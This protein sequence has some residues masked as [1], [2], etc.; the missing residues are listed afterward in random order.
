MRKISVLLITALL[1]LLSACQSSIDAGTEPALTTELMEFSA[2]TQPLQQ[3]ES[4]E[5]AEQAAPTQA[6][7]PT[8]EAHT[9]EYSQTTVKPTCTEDGY[10][11][12]T[13]ECGDSYKEDYVN[14]NGHTWGNWK[15][16]TEA[17]ETK[18]GMEK[19]TCSV[20]SQS[21]SRATAKIIPNHTHEYVET[22]ATKA[23]C[24]N[25]GV[26]TFACSCGHTYTES[27]A[28]TSHQY[29]HTIIAPTCTD[30][31]YTLYT[32]SCGD[33]YK[34]Q[35]TSA[36]GHSWGSWK[37]TK[38]PTTTSA[39]TKE[40]TCEKCG[41]KET[42]SIEK[43]TATEPETTAPATTE[44]PHTHS[45][46]VTEQK[47]ADCENYGYITQTCS[48]GKVET[49]L[50]TPTGHSWGEWKVTKEPTTTSAGTKERTC[51]KCGIKETASIEK[52][53][54]TEPETTAP[55]TTEPPHTHSYTV[56]D[57]KD[58]DCENDGY[59]TKNCSCGDVQT[60]TIA[61]KGH[62]W[63]H[64]DEVGHNDIYLECTCGWRCMYDGVNDEAT[65]VQ[66]DAHLASLPISE[67]FT[68]SYHNT[69]EWVVDTAGYDQCSVCQ[70]IK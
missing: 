40:R 35:S 57:Q 70:K 38:E 10:T 50:I 43:L 25:E 26:K 34:V 19:R 59:I 5:P 1:L 39:G 33:S 3:V 16:I 37:V 64:H 14:Q 24:K 66:Y 30:D 63:V 28:K 21:E 53:T 11:L 58:A 18:E 68:H 6:V 67:R 29:Q 15:T 61:A 31:G 41:I 46:T 54:A 45:Y 52:L 4:T 60:I 13:C 49:T 36:T 55:A 48:C 47:D 42:A 8:A 9:H 17:T 62:S 69:R 12:Y 22:I 56:T 27:I 23:T 44:P 32:C 51:E 2:E 7:D 65:Y 20:C